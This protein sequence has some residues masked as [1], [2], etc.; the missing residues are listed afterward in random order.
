MVPVWVALLGLLTGVSGLVGM[1][2]N[3]TPTVSVVAGVN[4]YLLPLW[5]VGFGIVLLR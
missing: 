2:R 4:N 5:M 3:L 1:L